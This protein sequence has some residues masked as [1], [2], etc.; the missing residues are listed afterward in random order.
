MI[1]ALATPAA[2]ATLEIVVQGVRNG[3]GE[4]RIAICSEARFLQPTCEWMRTVPAQTGD[5]VLR[6]EIPPGTWAAQAH[7]D[8]NRNGIIDTILGIPVEGLGFSNDARFPFGP[9]RWSEAAFQ[10]APQGG[11]I[12]FTM[13]YKF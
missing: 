9:P 8:E 11:R 10:L 6:L 3:E 2:A 4:I 12:R 1:L 5:V 13:R 7:H